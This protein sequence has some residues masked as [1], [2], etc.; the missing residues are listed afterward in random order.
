[1]AT[2]VGD[3]YSCAPGGRIAAGRHLLP[4]WLSAMP[5]H[6]W[7]TPGSNTISSVDPAI[8]PAVNPN[9]PATPPWWGS[10]GHGSVIT[11][12]CGGAWDE[13]KKQLFVTGG[14]HADYGGNEVYV[15]SAQTGAFSRINKPTG[16][17]GNTGNLIDGL[18]ATIPTLFDGQPRAAHT[19]GNLRVVNGEFWNFQGAVWYAGFGAISAFK[20][21]GTSWVRQTTRIFPECYGM[22]VWDSTRQRF[23]IVSSGNAIPVFWKPSDDTTGSIG[24]GTGYT[25]GSSGVYGDYDPLRDII[26]QFSTNVTCLK[27]DGSADAVTITATGTAPNWATYLPE[28]HS[29]GAG[30]VRDA[31]NDRWLIW[32]GGTSIYV[33]T[34][35]AVVQNPLTA[36]WV[37]SK[38]DADASN[39]VTPTAPTAHGTFGRFW[40]SPSLKCCGVVNSVTQKMYVFRI[41]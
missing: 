5:V 35:P 29:S 11:A 36:T 34:P 9:Y 1:M 33:L 14:G 31:A 32:G 4:A 10:N 12:W 7:A 17:I 3:S 26:L 23:V 28:G 25:N 18:D 2:P 16:A 15:W 19:Y 41:E 21:V 37:W 24:I 39:T 20:L 30:V 40:Y 22:T 38:I 6:T 13:V 8:D 27:A